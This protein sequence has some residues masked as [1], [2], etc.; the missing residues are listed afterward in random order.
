MRGGRGLVH[1]VFLC[2]TSFV[3]CE[4]NDVRRRVRECG[5]EE[6]NRET[7]CLCRS[8]SWRKSNQPRHTIFD[9]RFTSDLHYHHHIALLHH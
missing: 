8:M 3:A 5:E 7:G 9:L 6:G 2:L 1:C 4:K